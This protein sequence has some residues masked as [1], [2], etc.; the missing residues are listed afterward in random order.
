MF[1]RGQPT[2]VTIDRILQQM[3]GALGPDL[4]NNNNSAGKQMKMKEGFCTGL[5]FSFGGF[6]PTFFFSIE[7]QNNESE[8]K[9]EKHVR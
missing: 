7:T 2:W 3:T 9:G 4:R 5:A 1:T 8:G 6:F